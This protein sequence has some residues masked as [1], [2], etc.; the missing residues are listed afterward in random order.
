MKAKKLFNV[1]V[2]TLKEGKLDKDKQYHKY[3][4][5]KWECFYHVTRE[6]AFHYMDCFDCKVIGYTKDKVVSP[7][8]GTQIFGKGYGNREFIFCV[9]DPVGKR[10]ITSPNHPHIGATKGAA[11]D[12]RVELLR[13]LIAEYN[14]NYSLPW[15]CLCRDEYVPKQLMPKGW[16]WVKEGEIKEGDLIWENDKAIFGYWREPHC[17][18]NDIKYGRMEFKCVDN[19]NLDESYE[20]CYP[21]VIRKKPTH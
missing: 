10:D 20:Y 8:V 15:M 3:A 19:P 16:E 17:F 6:L 12:R 2:L 9:A 11:F 21:F 4:I 18:E 7:E 13:H 1:Y 14:T 5:K